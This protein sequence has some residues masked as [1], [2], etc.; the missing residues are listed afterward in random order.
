[1]VSGVAV[2]SDRKDSLSLREKPNTALSDGT[3]CEMAVSPPQ[4]INNHFFHFQC[5]LEQ[6]ND[7]E[8]LPNASEPRQDFEAF[9]FSANLLMLEALALPRP[10][11]NRW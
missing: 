9:L 4:I 7:F 8:A 11:A 10:A 2:S 6:I 1:M 3:L 5:R